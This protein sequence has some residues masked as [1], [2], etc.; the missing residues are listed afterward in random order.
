MTDD[1]DPSDGT[2]QLPPDAP[3]NEPSP[4]PLAG[5][6]G[7]PPRP[8]SRKAARR[9]ARAERAASAPGPLEG[10]AT[11]EGL[12][13]GEPR[14]AEAAPV[15][16]ATPKVPSGTATPPPLDAAS[17]DPPRVPTGSPPIGRTPAPS[18][19]QDPSGERPR[20]PTPGAFASPR[21]PA[22][23]EAD[24]LPERRPS[25]PAQPLDRTAALGAVPSS[26]PST[27]R[28]RERERLERRDPVGRPPTPRAPVAPEHETG[29]AASDAAFAEPELL[30]ER[31][32]SAQPEPDSAYAP[33]A[34]VRRRRL[35]ATT[36]FYL[37]FAVAVVLFA[38]VVGGIGYEFGNVRGAAAARESQT[39]T[40]QLEAQCLRDVK[41]VGVGTGSGGNAAFSKAFEALA[42]ANRCAQTN[43]LPSLTPADLDEVTGVRYDGA[44]PPPPGDPRWSKPVAAPPKA[45]N[46]TGIVVRGL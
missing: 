17:A 11:P 28:D 30:P 42:G 18:P 4:S 2:G 31:P 23:P 3:G 20:T 39:R 44:L 16:T 33:P 29:A 10:P 41:A 38:L 25:G 27:N 22:R 40:L 45:G 13:G 21:P 32:R 46:A 43:R 35:S 26:D 8:V 36:R 15:G 19:R 12:S 1:R 7:A 34:P 5:D 9:E 24:P 14:A 37:G 6:S